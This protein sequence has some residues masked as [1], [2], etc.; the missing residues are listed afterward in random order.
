MTGLNPLFDLLS[1]PT[2]RRFM[3]FSDASTRTLRLAAFRAAHAL[4][5]PCTALMDG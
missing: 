4:C 2:L 3:P 1:R 5:M